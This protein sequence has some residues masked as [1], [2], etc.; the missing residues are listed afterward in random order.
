MYFLKSATSEVKNLEQC[1][2]LGKSFVPNDKT[3]QGRKI[4]ETIFHGSNERKIL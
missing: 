2:Y 3:T 1:I 4:L